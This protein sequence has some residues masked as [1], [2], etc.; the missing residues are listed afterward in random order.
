MNGDVKSTIYDSPGCFYFNDKLGIQTLTQSLRGQVTLQSLLRYYRM[1][2]KRVKGK[3][4]RSLVKGTLPHQRR[5]HLNSHY[6]IEIFNVYSLSSKHYLSWD[7]GALRG[8]R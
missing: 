1:D 5:C 8:L 4:K 3:R 2:Y 7:P 6:L